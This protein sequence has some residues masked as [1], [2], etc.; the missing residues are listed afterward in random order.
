MLR[1][2][3]KGRGLLNFCS[4]SFHKL[5]VIMKSM[6][7]YIAAVLCAVALTACGGGSS[8][9]TTPT[10]TQPDFKIIE[11]VVGTGTVAAAGDLL[12]VNYTGYLYDA[13]QSNFK[14]AKIDSS[15]DRQSPFSFSVGV[16]QFL[17]GWDQGLVGM[18]A[19]GKRTLILP[20]SL[21]YGATKRD[22]LPAVNGNT[23]AAIPANSALVYDI[24]LVSV[25]KATTPVVVPPP[26]SLKIEELTVGTGD[27]ITTDKTVY[28]YYTGWIYDGSRIDLKGGQF[29][30]NVGGNKLCVNL[31][32]ANAAS[33]C[34]SVITGFAQG[35]NGMKVGGKRRVTIPPSLGY[36]ANGQGSIPGNATLIFEITL[37]SVK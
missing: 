14:G 35:L 10:V 8:K 26:T 15:I 28:V 29:D 16:G 18:K 27:T 20:A 37:D 25:Q 21:A 23:Y 2:K 1:R 31:G 30:S 6:F 5:K 19:G 32:T 34:T 9:S 17:V 36:G 7:Q 24:E 13:N 22:A 11:N 12:V 33:P 4:A 3:R